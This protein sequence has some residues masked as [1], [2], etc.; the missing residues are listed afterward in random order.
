MSRGVGAG[1]SRP[2]RR[3]HT[4]GDQ[5]GSMGSQR[6]MPQAQSV[7]AE[8]PSLVVRARGWLTSAALLG[9]LLVWA[10]PH[11]DQTF[12]SATWPLL[13]ELV[14]HAEQ[15]GQRVR[16]VVL[17]VLVA[18]VAAWL[19]EAW[20]SRQRRRLI[21]QVARLL[22]VYPQQLR[23]RLVTGWRA[24]LRAWVRIP[25][26][27][28]FEDEQLDEA[29]D[30]ISRAWGYVYRLSHDEL[31]DRITIVRALRRGIDTDAVDDQD[32]VSY[33][34]AAHERL[35][36]VKDSLPIK[37][38]R[39]DALDHDET[40]GVPTAYDI[41]YQ[42]TAN[43]AIE[44]W[45]ARVSTAIVGLV[46]EPPQGYEWSTEW[47]PSED[48]VRLS[49]TESEPDPEPL[50]TFLRHPVITDYPTATGTDR[51]VLPYATGSSGNY[52]SWDVDPGT[53]TPH[54][55]IVG[56]TGGGKTTAVGTLIS[57]GSLR[58]IPWLLLDPKRFELTRFG[59]H[60]GVIGVATD[61]ESI[62]TTI[63]LLW[64][65]KE[66]RE[67]YRERRPW[68]SDADMPILGI[69]IDEFM[70]LSFLL[71]QAMKH[72]DDIKAADPK[73]KLN[74]M[75]TVLRSIG[76]RMAFLVQRPDSNLWGGGN[77]RDNLG[78]RLAMSRNSA[79]GDKMMFDQVGVTDS[80]DQSIRGRG[81]GTTLA[82]TPEE[83]Q[84]W[85][86]PNLNPHPR[87]RASLSPEDRAHVD[88]LMPAQSPSTN[89]WVPSHEWDFLRPKFSA[90][91][92]DDADDD[93]P[94]HREPSQPSPPESSA[95]RG[96]VSQADLDTAIAASQLAPAMRIAAEID[97]TMVPGTVT[98]IEPD[99]DRLALDVALDGEQGVE[100]LIVDRGEMIALV[101]GTAST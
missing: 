65:E 53:N 40:L 91:G 81:V 46:G 36:N 100:S 75:V 48:R 51:L 84:V 95:A 79:D 54:G 12:N 62:I 32:E 80:L 94:E 23:L 15:L 29:A 42:K 98:D 76:G 74:I 69:V 82:G 33:S 16:P 27:Y 2:D 85:Y 61:I 67:Q 47:V 24:P 37:A 39:V 101:S 52:L 45:Q 56:P 83:C 5:M 14:G 4:K 55:L 72:D 26:G 41:H 20:A 71:Q 68:V 88:Q 28:V 63:E 89:L 21:D 66:A 60:P 92:S 64:Q 18:A 90:D 6:S 99:G 38:T 57:E 11:L 73:S 22:K 7:P 43:A 17:G 1:V 30:A 49:L 97:G 19:V 3:E 44:T 86:T 78:M 50:P 96:E 87:V 31:H 77:P 25:A 8:R 35:D 9:G 10:V 59:Y 34:S 93:G 70:L 58:S 13:R